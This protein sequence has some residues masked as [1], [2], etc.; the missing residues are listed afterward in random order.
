[1]SHHQVRKRMKATSIADQLKQSNAMMMPSKK[2]VLP[3]EI[4]F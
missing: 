3:I 1:M 4:K 2:G